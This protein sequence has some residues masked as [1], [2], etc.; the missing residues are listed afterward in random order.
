MTK[1]LVGEIS[2]FG[3]RYCPFN[4]LNGSHI[5]DS[6]C[7]TTIVRSDTSFSFAFDHTRKLDI[8]FTCF[9]AHNSFYLHLQ[10][11]SHLY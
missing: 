2:L 6:K 3:S 4:E 10:S 7:P 9:D 5:W 11:T 1:L 8:E